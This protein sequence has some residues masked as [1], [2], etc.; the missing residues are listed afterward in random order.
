MDAPFSELCLAQRRV[1]AL[2]V[3]LDGKVQPCEW[4]LQDSCLGATS[5]VLETY[6][7]TQPVA[8][9]NFW[10]EWSCPDCGRKPEIA[11]QVP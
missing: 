5:P 4:S 9:L 10:G 8:Q 2:G 3:W 6:P 11:T 1:V 7:L